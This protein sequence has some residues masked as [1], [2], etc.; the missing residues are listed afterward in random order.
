MHELQ[1]LKEFKTQTGDNNS[2][3]LFSVSIQTQILS[4]GFLIC[5]INITQV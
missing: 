1:S 2:K 3:F 5:P 4:L